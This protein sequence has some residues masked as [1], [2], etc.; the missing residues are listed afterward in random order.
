M[1]IEGDLA[2]VSVRDQ[3]PRHSRRIQGRIFG[4]FQQAERSSSRRHGGTGLGL[5]IARAIVERHE[6]QISFRTERGAGTTFVVEL[7]CSVGAM[8]SE[9]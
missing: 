6:G 2:R 8:T 9:E 4:K 3:R 7:P 5:A 1:E